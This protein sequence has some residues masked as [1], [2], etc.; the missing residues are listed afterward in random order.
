MPGGVS[1]WNAKKDLTWEPLRAELVAAVRY[2]HVL[3]GRF[4]HGGRLVR[5]PPDREPASCTYD[6]LEEVAPAEDRTRGAQGKSV[7]IRVE[8][9]GR[10]KI[11]EHKTTN[12]T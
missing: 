8:S 6:Q 3:A 2:E 9:C 10:R 7:P 1:R 4:R 5:F 12:T 11:Q